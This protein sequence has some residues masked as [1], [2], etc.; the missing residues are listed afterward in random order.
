MTMYVRKQILS[1]NTA[2]NNLNHA[3]RL[4]HGK[5]YAVP[6][7]RLLELAASSNCTVYDCEF[8]AL[9]L[10]L[11]IKLLTVDRQILTQFPETAVELSEFAGN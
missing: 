5:E 11:G 8:V 6:P 4:L 9:A 10:D 1:W 3:L 2:R 7:Q